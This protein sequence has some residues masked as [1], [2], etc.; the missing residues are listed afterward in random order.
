MRVGQFIGVFLNFK[1]KLDKKRKVTW[2]TSISLTRVD[3]TTVTSTC[4]WKDMKNGQSR[5]ATHVA[6]IN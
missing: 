5:L 2:E 3:G 6:K 1:S 4:D